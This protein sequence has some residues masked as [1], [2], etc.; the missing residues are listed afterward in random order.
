MLL[1]LLQLLL[2]DFSISHY[3]PFRYMQISACPVSIENAVNYL[4]ELGKM[5]LA[6]LRDTA[7]R[8]RQ[9]RVCKSSYSHN[10]YQAASHMTSIGLEIHDLGLCNS[11]SLG[12]PRSCSHGY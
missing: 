11:H 1:I 9:D 5:I 6:L 4:S 7:T 3:L 2:I 12:N 8:N 10:N